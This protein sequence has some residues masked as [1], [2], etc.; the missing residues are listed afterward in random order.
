M[1]YIFQIFWQLF[2][3]HTIS[4]FTFQVIFLFLTAFDE[5]LEMQPMT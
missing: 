4:V 2:V 5:I 1:Y 3:D